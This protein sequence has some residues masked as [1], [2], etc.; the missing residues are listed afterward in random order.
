MSSALLVESAGARATVQDLGRPGLAHLGVPPSGALDRRALR[1]ANRLL[2]NPDAAAGLEVLLGGCTLRARGELVLAVTGAPAP[3][4]LDG[5]PRA[6]AGPVRV[7]D[8][9]VLRVG[10]PLTGLRSYVGVAGGIAVVPVLGSRSTDTLSG[11]GP[12]PVRDG[13]LLTVGPATTPVPNGLLALADAPVD[14]PAVGLRFGPRAD[15]LTT[16]GRAQLLRQPWEVSADSD[17]VGVRLAGRPLEQASAAELPSEGLVTGS[18]QVPPDGLPL[19]FLADHP[20]TGGYPVVAVV[21][22]AGLDVLAQAR[23]GAVV[24]FTTAPTRR[25]GR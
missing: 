22:E 13:T 25:M 15:R 9:A 4:S 23:P 8:G 12:A 21:D 17:R 5:A 11:L 1:L 19:V 7:P 14:P 3:V 18:V 24:R 20:T 2:G 6:W 10:T 16:A